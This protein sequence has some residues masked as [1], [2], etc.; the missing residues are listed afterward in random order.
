MKNGY[1]GCCSPRSEHEE[2]RVHRR[3]RRR[4]TTSGS[5]RAEPAAAAEGGGGSRD[6]GLRMDLLH[7]EPG[8]TIGLGEKLRPH[9]V[10]VTRGRREKAPVL[11]DAGDVPPSRWW[12]M[13]DLS[14]WAVSSRAFCRYP[15]GS[16]LP[17]QPIDA[18]GQVALLRLPP[19][20]TARRRR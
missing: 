20:A 8:P 3:S 1:P 5:E 17:L 19:S 18:R 9:L 2:H 4:R 6:A 10:F 7:A 14:S 11:A 15:T 12:L 13:L 16:R